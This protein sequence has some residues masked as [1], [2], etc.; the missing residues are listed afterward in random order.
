MVEHGIIGEEGGGGRRRWPGRG[1]IHSLS[2]MSIETEREEGEGEG[3]GWHSCFAPRARG[4]DC[5][6]RGSEHLAG[7]K[8]REEEEEEEEGEGEAEG[9]GEGEGEGDRVLLTL[10]GGERRSLFV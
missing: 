9:E 4:R 5:L 7:G 3:I 6:V 1:L 2:E 10:R 8:W